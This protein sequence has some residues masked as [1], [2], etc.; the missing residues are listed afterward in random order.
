MARPSS[1]RI[2]PRFSIAACTVRWTI[3]Q[4]AVASAA[5]PEASLTTPGNGN[6]ASSD[7]STALYVPLAHQVRELPPVTLQHVDVDS[8]VFRR[9]LPI[10]AEVDLDRAAVNG[11]ADFAFHQRLQG[12][13]AFGRADGKLE[14]AVVD[15]AD[16]DRHGQAVLFRVRFAEAGHAL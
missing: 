8:I 14:V 13:V 5:S 2:R 1:P 3:G 4:S 9:A 16:F 10:D 11:A 7:G 15:G 6:S 12:G